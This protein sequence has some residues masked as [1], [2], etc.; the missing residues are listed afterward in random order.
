MGVFP[1]GYEKDEFIKFLQ[2]INVSNSTIEKFKKIPEYL[3]YKNSEY[4][5]NIIST[6]YGIDNT[7]YTFELNYY[8]EKLVEFLFTYKIFTDVDKSINYLLCELI[9]DKYI[10]K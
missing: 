3:T 8:S 7:Y 9:K 5:L 10:T 6:W 2:N 1:K 4:K